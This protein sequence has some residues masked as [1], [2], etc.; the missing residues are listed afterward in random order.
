MRNLTLTRQLH[1]FLTIAEALALLLV[2]QQRVAL[3]P[4]LQLVEHHEGIDVSLDPIAHE[5][6]G[7]L[8]LHVA[9]RDAVQALAAGLLAQL[10]DVVLGEARQVPAVVK[11]QL[12]QQRSQ[13]I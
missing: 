9:R 10:L 3:E 7:D 1:L 2:G 13:P 12:L 4:L 5:R 11:L 6:V 8:V